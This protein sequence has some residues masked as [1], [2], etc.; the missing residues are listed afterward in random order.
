MGLPRA[1]G[2]DG[3]HQRAH[4]VRVQ[5]ATRVVKQDRVDIR[6]GGE[7]VRLVGIVVVGVHRAQRE[8]D[9]ARHLR[10]ELLGHFG[11][12]VSLVDVEEHVVD[13]EAAAAVH[14]KLPHPHVHQCVGRDAEGD[15]RIAAHAAADRAV[16]HGIDQEIEPLPR[17]LAAMADQHLEEARS[18]EVHHAVACPVDHRRDGERHAGLHAHAPQALLPVP[19]GFVEKFDVRHRRSARLSASARA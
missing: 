6:R 15:A 11:E 19:H 7:P 17:V 14:A 9:G 16:G 12:T 13:P 8:H 5:H 3:G 2:H 10:A 1:F 4:A 18:G